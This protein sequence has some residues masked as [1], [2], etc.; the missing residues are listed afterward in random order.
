MEEDNKKSKKLVVILVVILLIILLVVG[1]VIVFKNKET[2]TINPQSIEVGNI[3]KEK[4]DN[5][6]TNKSKNSQ[7]INTFKIVS[8]DIYMNVPNWQKI[9]EGYTDVFILHGKKYIAVTGI[10]KSNNPTLS[11]A[12][13]QGFK[14]F[15]MSIQNYSYVNKLIAEKEETKTINGIKVYR[16]E[17]KLNCGHDTIYD[18]YAVGYS[19]VMDGIACNIIGSVIDKSQPQDEIN[20]MR[21]LVDTM[22]M[23]VRSKE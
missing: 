9:E 13:E 12:H 17:G 14:E 23:T 5:N 6:N 21:E 20:S 18:A 7:L 10:L 19:F 11:E 22:M 8:K 4:T 1:V 15:Q 16:Y 2:N 3:S